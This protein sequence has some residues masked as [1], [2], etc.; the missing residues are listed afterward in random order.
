MS[1]LNPS[2][3]HPKAKEEVHQ[4]AYRKSK[5]DLRSTEA[6]KQIEVKRNQNT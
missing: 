2:E 4:L 1:L 6:I 3:K 5:V